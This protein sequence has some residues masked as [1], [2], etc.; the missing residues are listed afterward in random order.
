M[1]QNAGLSESGAL[2]ITPNAN[3]AGANGACVRTNTT[4]DSAGVIAEVSQI[5]QGAQSATTLTITTGP[6]I[7]QISASSTSLIMTDGSNNSTITYDAP[8]MRWWRIRPAPG[9]GT[10]FETASD[11]TD[12]Q[13]KYQ[14]GLEAAA[15]VTVTISG[16]TNLATAA[17]GSARF[18]SINV[19]P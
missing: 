18:E 8:N 3:T 2:I 15:S 13:M 1:F 10:Q 5:V 14:V 6:D 17:P 12:W 16:R 4:Y 19:C 11:G 9:G 7:L